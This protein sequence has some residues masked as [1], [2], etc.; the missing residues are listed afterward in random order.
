VDLELKLNNVLLEGDQ[1]RGMPTITVD[2]CNESQPQNE[3]D[4]TTRSG[5]W[6]GGGDGAVF[7][8]DQ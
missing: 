7:S 6:G 4:R 3:D 8:M 5:E 1:S 2:D